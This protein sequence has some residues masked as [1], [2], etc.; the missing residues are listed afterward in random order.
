MVDKLRKKS[1]SPATAAN[2]LPRLLLTETEAADALNISARLLWQL[3]NIGKIKCVYIE[4]C[5]RYSV[6]ELRRYVASLMPGAA[7]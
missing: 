4:R 6:D 7:E 3:N 1:N 5:K 2:T